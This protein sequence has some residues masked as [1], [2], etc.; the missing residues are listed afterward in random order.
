MWAHN[1]AAYWEYVDGERGGVRRRGGAQRASRAGRP[2][3]CPPPRA[4][5]S[6]LHPLHARSPAAPPRWPAGGGKG[7]GQGRGKEMAVVPTAAGA[8]ALPRKGPACAEGTPRLSRKPSRAA[9]AG[10]LADGM[11]GSRAGRQA[12]THLVHHAL[13]V[14]RALALKL[15]ADHHNLHV[16]TCMRAGGCGPGRGACGNGGAAT[17]GAKR[18]CMEPT[19]HTCHADGLSSFR[20]CAWTHTPGPVLS[21]TSHPL[22]P[23]RRPACPPP[24]Q[25]AHRARPGSWTA[26]APS[27]G[28]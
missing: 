8:F 22:L 11:G 25:A 20:R 17:A 12:S 2:L 18:C 23:H 27:A 15:L 16:P 19:K 28:Q 3:T 7:R 1:G 26:F 13:P 24:S 21:T 9:H 4:F 14:D 5:S 10:K 6:P